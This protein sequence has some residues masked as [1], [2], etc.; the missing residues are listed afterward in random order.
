MVKDYV[1]VAVM[2]VECYCGCC[3]M[4]TGF[5]GSVLWGPVREGREGEG[6][7]RL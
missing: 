5:E 6:R 4:P 1:V 2:V 3:V 7:Q